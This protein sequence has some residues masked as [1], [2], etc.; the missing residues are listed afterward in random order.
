MSSA[1]DLQPSA[2]EKE[3]RDS[4]LAAIRARP[5]STDAQKVDFNRQGFEQRWQGT[6]SYTS[7]AK[8]E[9]SIELQCHSGHIGGAVYTTAFAMARYLESAEVAAKLPT[10]G[11]VLEL[12]AGT[13]MVGIVLSSIMRRVVY[14]TELADN[15]ENLQHNASRNARPDAPAAMV[16]ELEWGA[17]GE[18]RPQAAGDSDVDEPTAR[19]MEELRTADI[20]LIVG[21]DLVYTKEIGENL[22]RAFDRVSE[23]A[24]TATILFGYDLCGRPG[25]KAVL[26]GLSERYE[27]ELVLGSTL[28]SV[29][30]DVDTTNVEML[31]LRKKDAKAGADATP[32]ADDAEGVEV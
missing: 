32:A 21:A 24:P 20:R 31:W 14:V 7:L 17:A 27:V 30:P 18:W 15:L 26:R 9:R 4:L 3:R 25:L 23:V 19:T 5:T 28:T 16:R 6:Q 2:D 8:P 29:A 13:G 12:G 1:D 10:G 11:A 22:L